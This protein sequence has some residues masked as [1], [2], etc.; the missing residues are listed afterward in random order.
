MA[1]YGC[2]LTKLRGS[3][4]RALSAADK[5]LLRLP[6]GPGDTQQAA[7]LHGQGVRARGGVLPLCLQQRTCFCGESRAVEAGCWWT[8]NTAPEMSHQQHVCSTRGVQVICQV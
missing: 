3:G 1:A 5:T 4:S 7:G 2:S 8:E 6:L